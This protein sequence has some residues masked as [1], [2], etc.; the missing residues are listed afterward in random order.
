MTGSR[1][2]RGLG[3]IR[4]SAASRPLLFTAVTLAAVILTVGAAL[5]AREL[6]NQG[7]S[8]PAKQ[9]TKKLMWGPPYLADGTSL[10]PEYRDLGVGIF[11]VQ[12]R[13][14]EAAPDRR[15]EN[16]TDWR[17]PAYEWPVHVTDSIREAEKYGIKPNLMVMGAPPWA[18]SGEVGEWFKKPDDPQDFADFITAATDRYPSVRLW[19]VWGEPNRQP[20]FQPLAPQTLEQVNDPT[21]ELNAEQRVAPR[22]YAVLLDAAYE[23]IKEANPKNVVIGGNTYT[24]AGEDNIR[25]Y[26]WL[27]NM[28]LPDGS[29]P[30]MDM[31]GHNPW[32]NER[33][34]LDDP[35]S[36][37]GTVQFSDLGRLVK[38]LDGAGYETEGGKPL[39]LYLS[40]W[41]VGTGF[42]DK[43]LLQ[44]LD[45]ETADKW[46]AAAFEIADWK[47]IYTLGWVHP[48]DTERNS[49]GLMTEDGEPKSTYEAY[50]RQD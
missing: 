20:N 6:L 28:R 13:W 42:E 45:A 26:Q 48:T 14:E 37:N 27:D 19:K 15:P 29:L 24:S 3:G 36:P 41:G 4:R 32:G 44:E 21:Y 35:P 38:A 17:D 9:T 47:R 8:G 5:G 18:N 33:P 30:R 11:A 50:K 25:P 46:I 40:E 34:D 10:F 43:D 22:N 1:F 2:K 49:T 39:K 31:W 16:P 12:L 7:P 23:A